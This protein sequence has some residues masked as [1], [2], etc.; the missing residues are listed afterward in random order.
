VLEQL[1]VSYLAVTDSAVRAGG[2]AERFDAII[3]PS[4]SA[5]AIARGRAAGTAPPAYTGG[6]GA[7]GAEALRQFVEAG[8][9]LIALDQACRYVLRHVGAPALALR[10]RRPSAGSPDTTPSSPGE[11]GE[12]SRFFAPG[13]IFDV[14]VDRTHPI[15]SGMRGRVAV[16]FSSSTVLE[17]GPGARVVMRYPGSGALLSGYVDGAE[18]L[19]GRAALVDAPVGRGRV[20]LFGFRPQH[21]GQAH[22]TFRLLTNAI[23][24]GAGR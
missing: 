7:A 10:T 13:S 19:A 21:R 14:A 9:T 22:G 17:P 2:L 11:S 16:Y 15:A 6:L 3:L 18:V 4:E 20:I 23:L 12:V 1:G 5:D 24:S 8:G